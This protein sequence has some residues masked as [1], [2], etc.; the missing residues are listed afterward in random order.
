MQAKVQQRISVHERIVALGGSRATI[1]VLAIGMLLAWCALLFWYLL[2][3]FPY[4]G[5]YGQDAYAY[6]YQAKAILQ[7]MTGQ[8][9]QPWQL[10][11]GAQLYH[12]PVGYHLLI[13]VGQIITGSAAGGRAITIVLAG[14]AVI[15]L[16]LLVGELW[17]G[18]TFRTRVLAGLIAGGLL[19]LVATF[20]RMGLSVM[21]DV[22]ALFWGLLGIFCCLRAWPV[23]ERVN[24][25]AKSS[26]A[27][28]VAG[29][30][31]LG[32]AMLNRYGAIFFALP[33]VAYYLMRR[34]SRS[35]TQRRRAVTA[36]PAPWWALLGFVV[37]MLPQLVYLIA[38][39]EL[40]LTGA[41]GVSSGDWLNS[42]SP[43]NLFSTTV[44]GP[45]G[46][47]T[48]GQPMLV[49]YLLAP[50]YDSDAGFL[51]AFYLPAL[52]LGAGVI[53]RTR[54]WP[55][56]TLLVVWWLPPVF[57]FAGTP[58]QAQRFALTYVPVFLALIGVGAMTAIARL[59]ETV[60]G[61]DR[62]NRA[63]LA[64]AALVVIACL[65]L[66]VYKEQ[67]SVRG[68]MGIH[69]SFKVEEQAVLTLA[70]EAAGPYAE[71]NPP[72]LVAF[73]M[74]SALYHYTQWPTIELFNSDQE[75]VAHFLD[76]PGPHLLVI[77]EAGMSG[78]WAN[79]PLAARWH[80]LQS[81]YSLT[82]QGTARAYSVYTIG[83]RR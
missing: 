65:G 15:L 14:G 62:R 73:G 55:I 10:F 18:A 40:N 83:S 12:W 70:R 24:S 72:R 34:L 74:T 53:V 26:V 59:L 2:A 23:Q 43:G 64:A 82:P 16:Y 37:G 57:F 52:V 6:Y 13:I 5:L 47:S 17:P 29:G 42:W 30:L 76:S 11:S 81:N 75:T 3:R 63:P 69:E 51:S 1:N 8:A 50:L 28:A 78:Q 35:E 19:P 49:F 25:T 41:A 60:R 44:T 36:D 20:T 77:P 27:W 61:V 71:G 45:D 39:R 48:F 58:Y 46:T 54:I 80:W 33:V 79:T 67:G 4:D 7:D 32:L 56:V 9:S 31:A 22:P 68:W 21:A 66:G 38:Y